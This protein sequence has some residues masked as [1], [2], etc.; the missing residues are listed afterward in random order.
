[1]IFFPPESTYFYLR[2]YGRAG[3]D[4]VTSYLVSEK[5]AKLSQKQPNMENG[6]QSQTTEVRPAPLHFKSKV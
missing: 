4:D 2:F 3:S 5:T 1:M 6:R